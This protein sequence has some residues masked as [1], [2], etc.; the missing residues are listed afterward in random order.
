MFF[1][2]ITHL[3]YLQEISRVFSLLKTIFWRRDA[4]FFIPDE[5]NA[6]IL[7]QNTL[8]YKVTQSV[9]RVRTG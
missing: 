2:C 7:G 1:Y 5:F 4:I 8:Y 6:C 9:L 3:A